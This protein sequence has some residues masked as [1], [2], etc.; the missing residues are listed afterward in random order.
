MDRG[1]TSSDGPGESGASYQ[2]RQSAEGLPWRRYYIPLNLLF[3]AVL[4]TVLA[5]YRWLDAVLLV[6]SGSSGMLLTAF[7]L[8]LAADFFRSSSWRL[9][10]RAQGMR[11]TPA[12]AFLAQLVANY[13]MKVTPSNLGEFMRIYYLPST[14]HSPVGVLLSSHTADL[15]IG[16][17]ALLAIGEAS[18]VVLMSKGLFSLFQMMLAS[19]LALLFLAWLGFVFLYK[20]FHHRLFKWLDG[21]API[22]TMGLSLTTGTEDYH[23][24][25][26]RLRPARVPL[27]F[28]LQ[29]AAASVAYLAGY[30]LARSLGIA[31]PP[32]L[33]Y[34]C[35]AA[36]TLVSRVVPISVFDIGSGSAVL[37]REL[38]QLRVTRPQVSGYILMSALFSGVILPSLGAGLWFPKVGRK[39]APDPHAA[40][41]C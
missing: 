4:A 35:L 37:A 1:S 17:V 9:I 29:V 16:N 30:C 27:P 33:F 20:P 6:R 23:Q 11:I 41:F 40:T 39:S 13:W 5:R 18:L 3:L 12:R 21:L 38:S 25:L 28:C 22:R 34:L 14:S 36:A 7:A 24:S 19:V 32:L 8:F 31:L 15:L 2:R 26:A 10:A